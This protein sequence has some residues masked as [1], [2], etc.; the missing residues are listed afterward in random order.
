M[1]FVM[2]YCANGARSHFSLF[3]DV[4]EILIGHELR[5]I[6]DF[7][8]LFFEHGYFQVIDLKCLMCILKVLL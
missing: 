8:I 3:N 5:K 2:A 6:L 1:V 4:R 7:F